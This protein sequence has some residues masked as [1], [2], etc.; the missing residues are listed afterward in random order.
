[1]S[2]TSR[3]NPYQ[4]EWARRVKGINSTDSQAIKSGKKLIEVTEEQPESFS[5]K[6][7]TEFL[8]SY[9]ADS[10]P[11]NILAIGPFGSIYKRLIAPGLHELHKAYQAATQS[12]L[13]LN[14]ILSDMFDTSDKACD[15]LVRM[16][17]PAATREQAEEGRL[18]FQKAAQTK[19]I[20]SSELNTLLEANKQ[21]GKFRIGTMP[22]DLAIVTSHVDSHLK[23]AKGLSKHGVVNVVEKPMVAPIDAAQVNDMQTVVRDQNNTFAADF[24]PYADSVEVLKAHP[25]LVKGLGKLKEIHGTC[26]EPGNIEPGRGWLLD[27]KKAGGGIFIAD[28]A[29]HPVAW[30]DYILNWYLKEIAQTAQRV[31]LGDAEVGA[32]DTD[33]I[34]EDDL[35]KV[36]PVEELTGILRDNPEIE[37][38]GTLN[39]T[40]DIPESANQHTIDKQIELRIAAGKGVAGRFG[41]AQ[42]L[43]QF[44]KPSLGLELVFERGRVELSTGYSTYLPYIARI[45][46]RPTVADPIKLIKVKNGKMGYNNML[47]DWLLAAKGHVTDRIKAVSGAAKN[48][49]TLLH[50]AHQKIV[51][52]GIKPVI[53]RLGEIIQPRFTEIAHGFVNPL[54]PAEDKDFLTSPNF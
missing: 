50:K 10:A 14:W 32:V 45:P 17:K 43:R 21:Q 22:I 31:N 51:K 19:Y 27:Q 5:G 28:T 38:H 1:M 3:V 33:R 34:H 6:E 40:L 54:M 49:M 30:A 29:P 39:A 4:H 41:G 8:K 47:V 18:G 9:P 15:D 12:T 44:D 11:T 20:S 7:F 46:N 42:G 35:K 16:S 26:V 48:S 36:I 23:Y 24:F 52:D 53:H 2:T 25:E 37:T 13:K